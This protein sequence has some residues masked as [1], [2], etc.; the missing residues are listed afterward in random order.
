MTRPAAAREPAPYDVVVV[1]ARLAGAATA[2]LL[3]AAGLRVAVLE[4]GRRGS[5]TVS[6]HALMRTGVLQLRR[7]GL[8]PRIRAAGTP[9]IRRTVFHYGSGETT[10]VTLKPSA[11]VDALYAPRRTLLDAVLVD[12]ALE[13]GAEL[14]F[15]VRVTDL[16]FEDG[17]VVGVVADD[18]GVRSQVRAGLTIGADGIGSVVAARAGARAYRVGSA[19]PAV[20]YGYVEELEAE[21]YEWFYG[22]RAAAGFVPTNDGRVCVFGGAAAHR[23]RAAGGGPRERLHH[24]V[25]AASEPAGLRLAQARAVGSVR[26]FHGPRAYLRQAHGPGWALVGDA[27]YY[28]DPLSAHGMSDA[29]RDAEL[30]ARAVATAHARGVADPSSALAAYQRERDRLSADL[31]EVTD[32]I[33]G[34]G[35]DEDRLR[36]DLLRLSSAMSAEAEALLALDDDPWPPLSRL[37][38][39]P[40]P[41]QS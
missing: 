4:R 22:D 28:K 29:L 41:V 17:R 23:V 25:R 3:A 15:G 5:D 26:G 27:G 8:L 20:L 12:A 7:W 9:P 24:L 16:L 19:R 1:G 36:R 40:T 39:A 32:R 30:L 33:A 35:W 10:R 31:F 37:R 38:R 2:M 34:Y 14:R 13:A 21:G 6:T 11:G 18:G